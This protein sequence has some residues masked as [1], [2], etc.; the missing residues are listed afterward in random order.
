MN[1]LVRITVPAS[2]DYL[3]L[4][5]LVVRGVAARIDY[6]VGETDDLCLAVDEL[7][8][9]LFDET[10]TSFHVIQVEISWSELEIDVHCRL[11]A[12]IVRNSKYDSDVNIAVDDMSR[13]ILD[14]LVEEYG[15]SI[16]N[17]F[18]CA[19]LRKLRNLAAQSE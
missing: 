4:L 19:W 6:G 14:T 9:R 10:N 12:E 11:D 1:D 8:L 16:D 17:R 15:F 7:C 13:M 2:P 5:R 18:Q 3:T